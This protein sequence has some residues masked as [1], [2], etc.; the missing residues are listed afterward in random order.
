MADVAEKWED[1][2]NGEANE[3]WR[4]QIEDFVDDGAAHCHPDPSSVGLEMA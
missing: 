4:Q 3:D 1:N 2:I